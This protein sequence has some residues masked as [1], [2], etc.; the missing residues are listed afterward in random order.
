MR[1]LPCRPRA[2]LRRTTTGRCERCG[3]SDRGTGRRAPLLPAPSQPRMSCGRPAPRAHLVGS[4]AAGEAHANVGRR[5]AAD[6]TWPQGEPDRRSCRRGRRAPAQRPHPKGRRGRSLCNPRAQNVR[7]LRDAPS[8]GDRRAGS[9]VAGLARQ[10]RQI[11]PDL[12]DRPLPFA[13]VV[14]RRTR[15]RGRPAPAASR[16]PG[17]RRRAG[18]AAQPA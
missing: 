5:R 4:D 6:R 9:G 14:E 8:G 16:S 10:Q 12:G 18:P 1:S 17:S 11:D 13:V 15:D 3:R 7:W 2:G